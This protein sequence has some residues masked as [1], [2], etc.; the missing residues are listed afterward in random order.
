[1]G[2][3]QYIGPSLQF[4]LAVFLYGEHF[5]RAHVITFGCIWTALVIFTIDGV[6]RSR[7]PSAEPHTNLR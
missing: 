1:V 7:K 2:F 3:F 4:L 5:G 6:R